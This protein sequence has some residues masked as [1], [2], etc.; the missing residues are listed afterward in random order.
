MQGRPRI[1]QLLIEAF[2]TSVDG[3]GSQLPEPLEPTQIPK[4]SADCAI[5]WTDSKRLSRTLPRL[6]TN[7]LLRNQQLAASIFSPSGLWD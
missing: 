4:C 6:V 1:L 3:L 2:A 5:A 7:F